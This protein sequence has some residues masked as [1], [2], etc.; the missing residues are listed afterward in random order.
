MKILYVLENECR[1]FVGTAVYKA[2]MGIT[3]TEHKKITVQFVFRN[4]TVFIIPSY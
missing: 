2:H 1:V 3:P 4:C